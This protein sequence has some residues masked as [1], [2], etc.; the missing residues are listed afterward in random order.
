M[1]LWMFVAI[2]CCNYVLAQA[3]SDYKHEIAVSYGVAP[4]S[5]VYDAFDTFAFA[6]LVGEAKFGDESFFG[7]FSAEYFYH[8]IPLIGVGGI[9]AYTH[10]E[11]DV[12]AHKVKIGDRKK[13]YITVM[14]AVKFNWLRKTNWGMYSKVALGCTFA[15]VKEGITEVN[16]SSDDDDTFFNLQVSALGIE[17]GKN[18]RV[19][20]ELGYGEQGIVLAGVR[21]KF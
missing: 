16:L 20:A 13:N 15:S 1:R 10:N 12:L 18:F 4:Y 14:P 3:Q 17:A 7:P 6:S 2:L 5:D 8:V 9:F 11:Q 19:F 21:V